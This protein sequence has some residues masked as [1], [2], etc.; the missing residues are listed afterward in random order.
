[1]VKPDAFSGNIHEWWIGGAAPR[2]LWPAEL[3][4]LEGV[5]RPPK[6]GCQIR[7]R[8]KVKALGLGT[9]I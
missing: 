7:I 2:D 5:E 8:G 4:I 9:L 3:R 6:T 1:M